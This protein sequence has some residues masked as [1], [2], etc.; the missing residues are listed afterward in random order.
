MDSLL[1]ELSLVVEV[2]A[3]RLAKCV[4]DYAEFS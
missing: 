1:T 3:Q 2:Q 4:K